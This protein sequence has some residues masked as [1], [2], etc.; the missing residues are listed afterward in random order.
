MKLTE[1]QQEWKLD[2]TVDGT[3][4]DNE[5][6]KLPSLH[7]KY[8]EYLTNNNKILGK[9]KIK[10][11]E[12]EEKLHSYYSGTLNNKEDLNEIGKEP[13]ELKVLRGDIQRYI[14]SDKMMMNLNFKILDYEQITV[15]LQ[16]VLKS[17]NSRQFM[18]KNAIDWHKMTMGM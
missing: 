16:E 1:L 4:L 13:W 14:D 10:K 7:A 11:K 15:F 9:H 5:S 6:L 2:C 18:I 17:I 12:L 8:L 3:Q